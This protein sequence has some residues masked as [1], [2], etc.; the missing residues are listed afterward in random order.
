[1]VWFLGIDPGSTGGMG[2]LGPNGEFVEC[3]PLPPDPFDLAETIR[4]QMW[5]RL[6]SELCVIVEQQVPIRLGKGP[7]FGPSK[8]TFTHACGYGQ[9]L[10]VLGAL[11]LHPHLVMPGVWKKEL[12]LVGPSPAG[13]TGSRAEAE[14]KQRSQIKA[15]I[16]WPTA[17]IS[18]VKD[19][20]P[21]EAL[22]LAYY[23][24]LKGLG[25]SGSKE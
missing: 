10:G 21:S 9:I 12:R 5:P 17:P 14:R 19:D 2:W 22:L 1:M 11:K 13:L 23:A 6:Q 25:P 20:G 8:V 15:R 3:C 4:I 18:R 24:K 16:Y 7:Q